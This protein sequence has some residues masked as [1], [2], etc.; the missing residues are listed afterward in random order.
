[1]KMNNKM[2]KY[3]MK[4]MNKNKSK[5]ITEEEDFKQ[6]KMTK[7]KNKKLRMQIK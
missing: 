5:I 2:N 1:M 7:F 3:K 4:K 6:L